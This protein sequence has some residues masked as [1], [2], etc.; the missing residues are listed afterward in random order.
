MTPQSVLLSSLQPP[1]GNP[2]TALDP[3][4]LE[5]LA[6]SIRTDGLLQNLVVTRL[7]GRGER[8]RIVSGERRFRALKLLEEQA[9]ITGD[10][11]VP[12]EI[13]S[14]LSE[15]ETLRLATVE[16]LQRE[17]LPPLDEAAAFAGLVKDG[18][19]LDDLAAR[20]G[21]SLIVVSRNAPSPLIV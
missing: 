5:G 2:R 15:D 18:A 10:F 4:R 6:A 8:Y 16:D 3:D 17:N 13:R 19:R 7:K 14:K 12:V 9:E 20:T 1:K 21:L 11:A